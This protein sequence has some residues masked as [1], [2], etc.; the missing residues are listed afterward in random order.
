MVKNITGVI[1]AGG[2]NKR[3]N[4]ITK[5]NIVINGATIMTRIID[6]IRDIFNE[7]I[8]V[9]NTP[10]EFYKYSKCNIICDAI[11]N[12]GPLGGI[13]A[14]LRE[15]ENDSVFVFAGD[16]PYLDKEL[17]NSQISYYLKNKCDALV[18]QVKQNIEPL[19]AIY[20]KSIQ[21]VLENYLTEHHDYAVHRFVKIL[22]VS[23]L[24]LEESD[25][26]KRAFTNI[27]LQSDIPVIEKILRNGK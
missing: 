26:I 12:K 1:L 27:N 25:E 21:A 7:I 5:A 2:T 18:P 8:I 16:M 4:G 17:I 13:H 10:E 14:A 6:K 20:N 19:H 3:F 11:K 23:Y 9:T 15:S 24:K 22:N